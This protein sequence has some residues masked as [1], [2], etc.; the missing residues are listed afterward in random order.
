MR[1]QTTTPAKVPGDWVT[2]VRAASEA[3]RDNRRL[4]AIRKHIQR[5]GNLAKLAPSCQEVGA[6][7]HL[8]VAHA[9]QIERHH[10]IVFG[11]KRCNEG[12]AARMGEKAMR[13]KHLGLA[14][15]TPAK[16]VC[17]GPIDFHITFFAR[18]LEGRHEPFG[19]M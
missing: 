14:R 6:P 8:A 18:H 11:K 16:I 3:V 17:L 5:L 12:E 15:V 13:H 10:V 7:A 4:L 2:A 9:G 1:S 19:Q